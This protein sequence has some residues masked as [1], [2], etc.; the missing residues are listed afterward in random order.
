MLNSFQ[1]SHPDADLT[2][3]LGLYQYMQQSTLKADG[4]LAADAAKQYYQGM[5]G[6]R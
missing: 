2:Q 4:N 5:S 3:Q 1:Q 6:L